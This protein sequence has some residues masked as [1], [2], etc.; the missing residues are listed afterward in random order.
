MKTKKQGS[1]ALIKGE[2]TSLSSVITTDTQLTAMESSAAL[3][4]A[5]LNN[6]QLA[7][8]VAKNGDSL[9]CKMVEFKPYIRE[10]FTRFAHLKKNETILGCRTQQQFSEKYL[11]RTKRAVHL[12]LSDGK[13]AT[14]KNNYKD[15]T[16]AQLAA[17]E[18]LIGMYPAW[19]KKDTADA[20][21][22]VAKEVGDQNLDGIVK[23]VT[24]PYLAANK[25]LV[26][27]ATE[28]AIT[29][30]DTPA[31]KEELSLSPAVQKSGPDYKKLYRNALGG[32]RL[33]IDACVKADKHGTLP[34]DLRSAVRQAQAA[35][36]P[37]LYPPPSKKAKKPAKTPITVKVNVQEAPVY[38]TQIIHRDPPAMPTYLIVKYVGGSDPEKLPTE[39]QT[40]DD[41]FDAIDKL[42][43][44]AQ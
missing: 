36:F 34:A 24:A 20:V 17:V 37:T 12:M 42:M 31:K 6:G 23:A 18:V 4:A 40:Q 27:G 38:K 28:S 44:G 21:R 13:P 7:A 9:L 25:K 16:A 14:P 43:E 29:V 35:F 41:A 30:D 19:K 22:N 5:K 10:L 2:E 26:D 32:F 3:A 33:L 11:H 39:Y 8:Y 15:L 1:Q